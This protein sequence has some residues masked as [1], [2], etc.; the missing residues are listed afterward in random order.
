MALPWHCHGIGF[1]NKLDQ[2]SAEIDSFAVEAV[3]QSVSQT[4]AVGQR[5]FAVTPGGGSEWTL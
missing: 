3:S 5:F 4:I 2:L 1:V